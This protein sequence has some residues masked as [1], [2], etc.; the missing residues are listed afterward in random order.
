MGVSIAL[1]PT[2]KWGAEQPRPA[3]VRDFW[4][5]GRLKSSKSH[6]AP[7]LG[8]C[9]RPAHP[10]HRVLDTSVDFSVVLRRGNALG[11][12]GSNGTWDTPSTLSL[13]ASRGKERTH[14]EGAMATAEDYR[15]QAADLIRLADVAT[16]SA[17]KT[18]LLA[19]AEAWLALASVCCPGEVTSPTSLEA[20]GRKSLPDNGEP[21]MFLPAEHT[22]RQLT[23]RLSASRCEFALATV[24]APAIP[25]RS[26]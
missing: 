24:L 2:Q 19:L 22:G 8:L 15:R 23:W 5:R 9:F 10:V 18:A 1:C 4:L 25:C 13:C 16:N 11:P 7:T 12:G 17:D 3:T 20:R 6:S 14:A 21:S 26:L